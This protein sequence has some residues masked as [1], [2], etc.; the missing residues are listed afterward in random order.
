MEYSDHRKY[1]RGDDLRFLDWKAFARSDKLYIKRFQ[2]ETNVPVHIVLDS[3]QS[4]AFRGEAKYSK[5]EY[6][7]FLAAA[8]AFLMLGQGDS[9]GL[10][11]FNE[12]VRK[13]IPPRSRHTHLHAILTAL[14]QCQPEGQTHLGEVLHTFAEVT[15]R[16][17]LVF[18]ISDL[19]DDQEELQQSLA[20]LKY[21]QHDIVLF[22]TLDHM[23]LELP[24][25]GLVQFEDMES[26]QRLRVFPKAIRDS[27]LEK[28]GDYIETIQ[29]SAG[30]SE[31]DYCLLDTSKLL[32]NAFM[33]FL[34]KRRR[35]RK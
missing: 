33:A 35:M 9:V 13:K 12:S 8:L 17:G 18:L 34:A 22:H 11:L 32:D 28:V 7:C 24:Y 6:G 23:E 26:S 31:I 21:L 1:E 19:L 25:D 2:Q 29:K 14:Q 3:S 4:M 27:Y 5:Y 10:A 16:R 20:H 15:P 30:R